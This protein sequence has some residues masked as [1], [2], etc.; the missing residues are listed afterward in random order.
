MKNLP[1]IIATAVSAVALILGVVLYTNGN[2][3]LANQSALQKK[4][5][6]IQELNDAIDIQNREFQRQRQVIDQGANIAQKFGPP[7]LRD[8]GIL[9]VRNKNEKLKGLLV[10]HKMESFI[11]TAEQMKQIEEQL[12]KNEKDKPPGGAAPAPATNPN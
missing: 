5:Q 7:I 4:Q 1:F 10:R 6:K 2:A 8:I 11:P 9:S 3:N 12:Q